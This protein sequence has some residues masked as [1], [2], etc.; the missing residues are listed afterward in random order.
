M[1]FFEAL[2]TPTPSTAKPQKGNAAFIKRNLMMTVTRE[3]LVPEI[4]K[5]LYSFE[6]AVTRAVFDSQM[7]RLNF[8]DEIAKDQ[9]EKAIGK[10]TIPLPPPPKNPPLER[11][12][13]ELI[14]ETPFIALR[15]RYF[16]DK[17]RE[18][19]KVLKTCG[20]L[21]VLP[22]EE[23]I[24]EF[25]SYEDKGKAPQ[26]IDAAIDAD[27]LIVVDLEMPIHLEWHIRE[28]IERIGRLRTKKKAPIIS[29]WNRFND[30]NA[31]FKNFKIFDARYK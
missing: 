5:W 20:V 27:F 31:F 15:G 12:L 19:V 4:E 6:G 18:A 2:E 25:K 29:T 8:D 11:P 3:T 22:V 1:K 23:L 13:A 21:Y 26:M 17:I 28:A 10:R 30:C 9:L 16:K 24:Q 14:L 7:R